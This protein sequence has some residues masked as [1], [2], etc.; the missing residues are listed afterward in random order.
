MKAFGLV[1]ILALVSTYAQ[2]LP[3]TQN[4]GLININV[5]A[6]YVDA[7]IDYPRLGGSSDC[8][9]AV[10]SGNAL[11]WHFDLNDLARVLVLEEGM[12]FALPGLTSR[13]SITLSP[14]LVNET[15]LAYTFASQDLFIDGMRIRTADGRTLRD[16]LTSISNGNE[17]L[18]SFIGFQRTH[19]C[20]PN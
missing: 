17:P 7:R 18:P 14:L 12:H 13:G 1:L 19:V 8:L 15:F 9:V 2:A 10:A 6:P 16:A 3:S 20:D 11:F 5:D 4:L